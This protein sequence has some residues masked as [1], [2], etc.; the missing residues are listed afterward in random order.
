M[1]KSVPHVHHD[2]F[3]TLDRPIKFLICGVVTAV[4]VIYAKPSYFFAGEVGGAAYL[5]HHQCCSIR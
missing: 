4:P 1:H 3:S 2:Y 5:S